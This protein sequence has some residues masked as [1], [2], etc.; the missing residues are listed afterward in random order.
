MKHENNFKNRFIFISFNYKTNNAIVMQKSVILG[1]LFI[2][3]KAAILHFSCF[4][5]PQNV[6]VC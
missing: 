2:P 5:F 4:N 3:F 1:R 6:P